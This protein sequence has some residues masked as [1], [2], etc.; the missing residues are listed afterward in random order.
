MKIIINVTVDPSEIIALYREFTE[1]MK[2]KPDVDA[3]SAAVAKEI[4]AATKRTVGRPKKTEAKNDIDKE[5][6]AKIFE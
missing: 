3:L 6:E 2:A 1:N 5:I 4:T